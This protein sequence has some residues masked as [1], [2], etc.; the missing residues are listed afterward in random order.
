MH[1]IAR[2]RPKRSARIDSG[3]VS[4][5]T[6]RATTLVS[7]PS[8]AS[9]SAHWVLRSGKTAAS[10]CRHMKSESSSANDRPSTSHGKSGR[11][12]P[13]GPAT[14][15][16][17]A[18]GSRSPPPAGHDPLRAVLRAH[19]AGPGAPVAGTG[20]EVLAEPRG[21]GAGGGEAEQPG[22]LG[23]RVPLVGQVVRGE[24]GTGGLHDR[25]E[26]LPVGAQAP[27]QGSRLHA[28]AAADTGRR[29]SA[30]GQQ[31]FDQRADLVGQRG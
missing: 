31:E 7:A 11:T 29:A 30:Q 12:G 3:R 15:G 19:G 1:R 9:D 23:E 16:A 6:V 27:V 17:G 4:T 18:T 13:A 14:A 21:E 10:T 8:W 22:D 28:E 5:P 2:L 20:A 26:A 25:R 24:P